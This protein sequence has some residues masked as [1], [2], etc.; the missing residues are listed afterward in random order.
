MFYDQ[1]FLA[2]YKFANYE[3]YGVLICRLL[4][5]IALITLLWVSRIISS[6][7]VKFFSVIIALL[8]YFFP[9]VLNI[10]IF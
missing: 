2:L 9:N 6:V 5:P 1:I 4:A 7:L 10:F 3:V 8:L